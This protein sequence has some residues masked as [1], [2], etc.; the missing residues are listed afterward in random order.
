MAATTKMINTTARKFSQRIVDCF[1]RKAF[2]SFA[3]ASPP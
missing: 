2:A 1:W 3:G